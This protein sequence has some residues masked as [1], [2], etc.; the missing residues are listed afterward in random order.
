MGL[1]AR[2]LL[3]ILV[4]V[5]PALV[6]A[7]YTNLEQR[8]FGM[9]RVEKDAIRVVQLAAA[10]QLG[11]IE[12]TRQHLGALARLPPTRGTNLAVFDAFFAN[13]PKIYTDYNDFGLIET[14]GNLV[15]SAFGR[16][17]LTNLAAHAHFQRV[18]YTKDFT[19]GSYQAG[20]GTRKPSLLFGHPVFD[21]SGRL[22]RILYAAMDLAVLNGVTAKTKLPEGGVVTIFDRE[23]YVLGCHPEP[24]KWVGKAFPGS[25]L[26]RTILSRKE[27]TIET[28]G[29]D[30][31]PR[32]NAF[33]AIRNGQDANLFVSVGVPTSLAFAE[34]KHILV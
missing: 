30:G 9:F 3:L 22:A 23:G 26:V 19:I 10:N 33:T 16:T 8:R 11:L 29:L 5:I 25:P 31:V 27:G 24:E 4:S 28:P 1:R 20:D 18:L 7:L 17:G 21:E 2:L 13:M 12:A 15:A 14:N 34:I 6:L 32:L